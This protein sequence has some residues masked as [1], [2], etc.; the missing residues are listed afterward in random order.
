[1]HNGKSIMFW[2]FNVFSDLGFNVTLK[3][4]MH[5]FCYDLFLRDD[6]SCIQRCFLAT[7]T[8]V[9]YSTGQGVCLKRSLAEIIFTFSKL[10]EGDY[11]LAIASYISKYSSLFYLS[12]STSDYVQRL[13]YMARFK[14][15]I[16]ILIPK[17]LQIWWWNSIGHTACLSVTQHSTS[18]FSRTSCS[19]RKVCADAADAG[20]MP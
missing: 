14:N 3:K 12:V 18:W 4:E 13:V 5:W 19:L 8:L 11:L 7:Q 15:S 2:V 10:K 16:L 6:I 9:I 17:R 1:M 20:C